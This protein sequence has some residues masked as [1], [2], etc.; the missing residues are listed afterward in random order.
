MP[1]PTTRKELYSKHIKGN[2]NKKSFL[3]RRSTMIFFGLLSLISA[4][5]LIRSRWISP[6]SFKYA[7]VIDAGSTGTRIH[8]YKFNIKENSSLT[9]LNDDFHQIEPGLSHFSRI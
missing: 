6:G 1:L 8:I 4:F 7:I 2:H 5:Y 9:L 3:K